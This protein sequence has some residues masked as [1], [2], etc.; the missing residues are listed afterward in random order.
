MS[1]GMQGGV[2][3]SIASGAA[4][5]GDGANGGPGT[6]TSILDIIGGLKNVGL[7]GEEGTQLFTGEVLGGTGSGLG[8]LRDTGLFS[9]LLDAIF[10]GADVKSAFAAWADAESGGGSDGGSDDNAPFSAMEGADLGGVMG[11]EAVPHNELGALSPSP[12]PSIGGREE[13][14]GM[15]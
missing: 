9:K 7:K 2:N 3:S 12:T 1:D 13:G 4:F 11:G 6:V 10:A 14:I 15:F 5:G 8:G